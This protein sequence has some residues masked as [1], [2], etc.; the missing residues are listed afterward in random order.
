MTTRWQLLIASVMLSIPP[1]HASGDELP[2]DAAKSLKQYAGDVDTIRKKANADAKTRREKLIEDLKSVQAAYAKADK[3]DKALALRE[4]LKDYLTTED[5]WIPVGLL[6]DEALKRV[7][8]YEREADAIHAKAWKEIKARQDKAIKELSILKTDYT[9]ADKLDEAKSIRDEINKLRGI[10]SE[11]DRLQGK[12]Q[13]VLAKAFEIEVKPEDSFL[14]IKGYRMYCRGGD[15][16]SLTII[17]PINT[18]RQIDS[19][20]SQG[21]YRFEDENTLIICWGYFKHPRPTAFNV[22]TK[23]CSIS[24]LKRAAK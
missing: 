5:K 9:K 22:S 17:D 23:N 4:F 19:T 2:L 14:V 8:E 15:P 18:P 12:W 11:L 16:S 20:F 21:I 6:E 24:V 1:T 10:Q 3:L 7:Q 13:V